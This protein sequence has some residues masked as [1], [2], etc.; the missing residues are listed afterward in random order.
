MHPVELGLLG[1]RRT[2]GRLAPRN[3]CLPHARHPAKG[4]VARA[5]LAFLSSS[6]QL[7]HRINAS[8]ELRDRRKQKASVCVRGAAATT[9]DSVSSPRTHPSSLARQACSTRC[10]AP[11]RTP[12]PTIPPQ[13]RASNTS[14]RTTA[15][16]ATRK[17]RVAPCVTGRTRFKLSSSMKAV[18]LTRVDTPLTGGWRVTLVVQTKW[19]KCSLV[20]SNQNENE[21]KGSLPCFT[22]QTFTPGA[23]P[24]TAAAAAPRSQATS[25]MLPPGDFDWINRPWPPVGLYRDCSLKCA[26]SLS[27]LIEE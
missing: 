22:A 9:D 14:T 20:Q 5:R 16:A 4:H 11:V 12:P 21:T 24:A 23:R 2:S 25:P 27:R 7:L 19:R 10:A 15:A 26:A 18:W 3:A 8:D 1:A 17:Q 6:R 13:A